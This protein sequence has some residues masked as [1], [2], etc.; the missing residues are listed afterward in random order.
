MYLNTLL[1]GLKVLPK[2]PIG[3]K[4]KGKKIIEKI[5]PKNFYE[6]LKEK[7]KT[8]VYKINPNDKIRLL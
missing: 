6:K 4:N 1:N 8:C 5:G 7:N 3:L 2:I